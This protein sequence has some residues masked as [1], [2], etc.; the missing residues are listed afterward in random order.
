MVSSLAAVP[1]L[2]SSSTCFAGFF[3]A[4]AFFGGFADKFPVS[5]M[6]S[7]VPNYFP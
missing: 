3:L 2:V 1:V 5:F 7:E 6:E 4:F